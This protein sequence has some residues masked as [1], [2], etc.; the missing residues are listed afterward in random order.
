MHNSRIDDSNG[1]SNAIVLQ[2]EQSDSFLQYALSIIKCEII[3]DARDGLKPIH[4]R[5]VYA[6][7]QLR[8]Y[9]SSSHRRCA[10]VVGG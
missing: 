5:I 8:L 6:I 4:R 7:D 9:R 1:G 2:D 10:H 3:P